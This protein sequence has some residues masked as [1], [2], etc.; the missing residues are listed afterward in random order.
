MKGIVCD[1]E[2]LMQKLLGSYNN[3]SILDNIINLTKHIKYPFKNVEDINDFN[4]SR[5]LLM[6][7]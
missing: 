4:R 3:N 2:I 6:D 7:G 1:A 5:R